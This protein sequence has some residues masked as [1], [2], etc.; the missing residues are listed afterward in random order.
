MNGIVPGPLW[1][2][3][4]SS[5]DN[6]PNENRTLTHPSENAT[7]TGEMTESQEHL[8]NRERSGLAGSARELHPQI[9]ERN[10][11]GG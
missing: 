9:H 6:T 2:A 3:I 10:Q 7:V 8:V 1:L 11:R 4:A 5:V